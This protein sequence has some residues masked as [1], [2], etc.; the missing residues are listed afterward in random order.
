MSDSVT[1]YGRY[2]FGSDTAMPVIREVYAG[3]GGW[4][5]FREAGLKLNRGTATELRAEGITMVRVR[6]RLKTVEI[7]LLRYL[8]G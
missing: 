8:G 3:A 2:K 7:S 6:W 5:D 1:R 4:K